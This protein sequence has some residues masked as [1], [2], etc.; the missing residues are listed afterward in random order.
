[1]TTPAETDVVA[2]A[3]ISMPA[4]GWRRPE[5]RN[6]PVEQLLGVATVTVTMVSAAGP[7]EIA[8]PAHGDAARLVDESTVPTQATAGD[9]T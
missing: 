1:M 8:G 4:P 7:V 9:T 6:G 2:D 5:V 3:A